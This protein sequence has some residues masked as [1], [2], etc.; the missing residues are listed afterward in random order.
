MRSEQRQMMQNFPR[1]ICPCCGD[2]VKFVESEIHGACLL[3]QDKAHLLCQ[4]HCALRKL[5][6][7]LY[8]NI[9][10]RALFHCLNL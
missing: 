5:R 6:D 10:S 7:M 3:L 1:V 4:R 2:V 8:V 9:C